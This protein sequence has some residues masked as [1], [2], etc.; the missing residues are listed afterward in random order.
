MMA[1]G[2]GRML[3]EDGTT[4]NLAD[5]FGGTDTGEKQDIN[6]MMPRNGRFVKED[7]SVV[8]IADII[9]DFFA[10]LSGGG[11]AARKPL[12]IIVGDTTYT[13]TG[14]EAVALTIPEQAANKSLNL[15]IGGQSYTYDGSTQVDIS[16]PAAEGGVF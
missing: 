8:N 16:I 7:G 6:M 5:L 10:G 9:E 14:T 1:P 11:S 15:T 3:K 12:T 2:T 13:Y 4:V